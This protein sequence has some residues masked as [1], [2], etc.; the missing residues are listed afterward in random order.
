MMSKEVITKCLRCDGEL[1]VRKYTETLI[2][3]KVNEDGSFSEI[4]SQEETGDII[5]QYGEC[6][7]CHTK[8][9]IDEHGHVFNL[10]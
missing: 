9:C 7:E 4:I 1:V 5:T 6:Q 3:Y 10:I 2:S 8:Y